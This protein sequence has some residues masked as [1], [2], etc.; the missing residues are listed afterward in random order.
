MVAERSDATVPTTE[1]GLVD[2][3]TRIQR[4]LAR[5]LGTLLEEEGTSVD[6]WR[7]LRAL[8]AAEGIS[9]GE[10]AVALEIPHPTVTRL[11]DS[12]VDSAHL[13]R[14]HSSEDRRR[15]S[16]HLSELGRQKLDRLEAL[17]RAHEQALAA[18][19]GPDP[20]SDLSALLGTLWQCLR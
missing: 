6:Q 17:A 19:L 1:V 2:L 9:M 18:K 16:V 4:F 5:D 14:V 13:Y 7:V 10:L 20:V 8:D 11:V 12:L 3:L 15:V